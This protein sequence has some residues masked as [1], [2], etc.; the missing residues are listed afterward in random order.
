ME[1]P[2][3]DQMQDYEDKCYEEDDCISL[4]CG[5]F[6]GDMCLCGGMDCP[7]PKACDCDPGCECDD[8]PA[9][10]KYCGYKTLAPSRV[11]SQCSSRA[12]LGDPRYEDG[13]YAHDTARE[14]S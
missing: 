14:G 1:Q 3:L 13:D 9:D 12:D 4:E 11:C 2:Q 6:D 7:P 8:A 10:C 5:H